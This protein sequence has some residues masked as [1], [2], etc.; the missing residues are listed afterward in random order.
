MLA[1]L[2]RPPV[3]RQDQEQ[4]EIALCILM[5]SLRYLIYYRKSLSEVNA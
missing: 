1:E 2:L 3:R 4:M 5:Y